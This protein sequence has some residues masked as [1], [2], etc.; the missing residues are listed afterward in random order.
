[1]WAKL[2]QCAL[3]T[4]IKIF[5]HWL[6]KRREAILTEMNHTRAL[7]LSRIFHY[8]FSSG[9]KS[10]HN[11]TASSA[12][13]QPSMQSPIEILI[14]IFAMDNY[15]HLFWHIKQIGIPYHLASLSCH[16]DIVN[17]IKHLGV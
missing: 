6:I 4:S 14:G 1:M 8:F 16:M 11:Y 13:F 2:K 3:S 7:G 12:T 15:S 10:A 5:P 9:N 17:G